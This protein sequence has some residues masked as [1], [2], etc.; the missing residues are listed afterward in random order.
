MQPQFYCY[1]IIYWCTASGCYEMRANRLI[2]VWAIMHWWLDLLNETK[3]VWHLIGRGGGG[4]VDDALL[5]SSS[6][7]HL[8]FPS[9]GTEKYNSVMASN[10]V[11]RRWFCQHFNGFTSY[12]TFPYSSVCF[13]YF[14]I[15]YWINQIPQLLCRTGGKV[16]IPEEGFEIKLLYKKI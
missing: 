2:D 11:L 6:I 10:I 4:D 13:F 3:C 8:S 5:L 9:V 1:F 7:S 15:F 16:W 12:V 14:F